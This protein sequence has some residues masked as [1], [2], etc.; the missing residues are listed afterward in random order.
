MIEADKSI[1][2]R[3]IVE[4]I[5]QQ[6][7]NTYCDEPLCRQYAWWVLESIT[8]TTKNSLLLQDSI[9][10]SPEQANTL[11]RWIELQV[12]ENIP[13]QYLIGFVPFAGCEIIVEP[14]ILIPRPETEEWV[15]NLIALI[16]KSGTTNFRV[17]DLCT[18]SGCIAIAIAKAFPNAAVFATDISKQALMLAQKNAIHNRVSIEF[19]HAD[20]FTEI[21]DNLAFDLI[22][23]NPPYISAQE[24]KTLDPSVRMWEDNLALIAPQEGLGLL[25]SIITTAG[26]YLQPN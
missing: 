3:D 9:I 15:T 8:H 7:C 10:L 4:S 16:K 20:L 25:Y 6:L 18:G 1:K 2:V 23:A 14:P 13:L 19:I 21:P 17:L 24:W 26:N 12:K 5:A 11:N 22:I